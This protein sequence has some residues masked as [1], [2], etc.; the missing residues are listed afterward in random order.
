[1]LEKLRAYL[2]WMVIFVLGGCASHGPAPVSDR[3]GASDHT[4]AAPA[5]P[6]AGYYLVQPGDTL[7]GISRRVGVA[8]QDLVVWNGLTSPNQIVAGQ[9]LRLTPP[10]GVAQ[11][12]PIQPPEGAEVRPVAP[13]GG[14]PVGAAPYKDGPRGGRI[15]YTDQ[16][17]NQ[18]QSAD[19]GAAPAPAEPPRETP[20]PAAAPAASADWIWPADGKVISG[21]GEG[22][23]KGI[24][25]AGKAGDP[26]LA[27]AAGK[28]VYAGSGLRGYGKLVIIKHDD[29]FLSAY[30]HNRQLLV[31]EGQSVTKGQKIAELGNTDADRP[32]LHFEIRRQGKPVDPLKYLPSR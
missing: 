29:S 6:R 5:G 14:A 4:P 31:N 18:A 13:S 25:I 27:T 10:D 17:W 22:N 15:P 24:D 32:K 8:L 7:L 2:P 16:A 20:P 9:E 19:H 26:V 3:G 11:V 1:M 30:A 28:V 23:G 12:R 21:F